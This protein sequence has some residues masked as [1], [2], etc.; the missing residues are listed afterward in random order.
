MFVLHVYIHNANESL[1]LCIE[2]VFDVSIILN[3][4]GME[5]LQVIIGHLQPLHT[6]LNEVQ[7]ELQHTHAE[8]EREGGRG[9]GGRGR[10]GRRR[11]GVERE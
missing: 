7:V 8:E 4:S 9:E 11:E 10:Q 6:R 3:L 1:H 2:A 5:L